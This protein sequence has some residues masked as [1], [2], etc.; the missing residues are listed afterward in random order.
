[1]I[2]LDTQRIAINLI[3]CVTHSYSGGKN[4]IIV[5]QGMA[6]TVSPSNTSKPPST[7]AVFIVPMRSSDFRVHKIRKF[8]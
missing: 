8:Q 2:H 1:M 7:H 3:V 6:F 4:G 5:R